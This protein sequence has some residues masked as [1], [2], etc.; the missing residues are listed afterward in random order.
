M[1]LGAKAPHE[2]RLCAHQPGLGTGD[3]GDRLAVRVH[4]AFAD[5]RRAAEPDELRVGM[6]PPAHVGILAGRPGQAH[7]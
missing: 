4:W 6:E 2:H 5:G 1:R 7:V 3:T